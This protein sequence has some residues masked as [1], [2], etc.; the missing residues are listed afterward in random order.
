MNPLKAFVDN[1]MLVIK[2]EAPKETGDKEELIKYNNKIEI[3][4]KTI[5]VA[6]IKVEL[7]IPKV[8]ETRVVLA[9]LSRTAPMA[10]TIFATVPNHAPIRQI[11]S[12]QQLISLLSMIN[13][14]KTQRSRWL[15]LS[16]TQQRK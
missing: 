2:G 7:K 11:S 9:I 13:T 5:K 12:T 15:N 4:T 3:S 8:K 16:H 14:K 10:I 1:D 6:I